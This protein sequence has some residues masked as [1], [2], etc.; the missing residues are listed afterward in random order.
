[1]GLGG[2]EFHDSLFLQHQ[3]EAKQEKQRQLI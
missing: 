1:M 2:G 3:L